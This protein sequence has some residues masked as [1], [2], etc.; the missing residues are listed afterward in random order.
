MHAMHAMLSIPAVKAL[1]FDSGFLVA[2][3]MDGKHNDPFVPAPALDA[4]SEKMGTPK[5]RLQTKTSHS[6]GI[7]GGISNGVGNWID[8]P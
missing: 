5:S 3:M 1:E 4:A 2:E 7:Q 6:S 8:V